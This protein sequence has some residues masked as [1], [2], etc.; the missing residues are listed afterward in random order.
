MALVGFLGIS[1]LVGCGQNNIGRLFDRDPGGGPGGTTG[2][3]TIPAR[4]DALDSRPSVTEAFPQGG[5]WPTA[6]P[7]VV[8]FNESMNTDLLVPT[9]GD[10]Q[11][12]VRVAGTDVPLPA[13]YDFLFGATVL[14]IRPAVPLSGEVGVSYEVVVDPEAR[15]VDGIRF[16]GLEPEVVAGRYAEWHR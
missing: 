7:V 6:V 3:V 5:G 9:T 8:V 12:F 16:G 4:G 2:V 13:T 1:L 15:D 11:V 10:P 14:L